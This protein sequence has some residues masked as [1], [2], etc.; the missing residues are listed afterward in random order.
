[1]VDGESGERQ[2]GPAGQ[3]VPRLPLGSQK[4]YEAGHAVLFL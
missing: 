3:Q 2:V 1:M 4:L